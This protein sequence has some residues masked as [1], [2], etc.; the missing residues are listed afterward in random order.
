MGVAEA[1]QALADAVTQCKFEATYPA[2][3]E[4]VLNRI[5]DVLVACV[6]S[7]WGRLLSHDNLLN[8]FQACYR[9]GHYQTEKGRDTSG[10]AA[11]GAG[12]AL[13][14]PAGGGGA[15]RGLPHWDLLCLKREPLLVVEKRGLTRTSLLSR[16]RRA[17]DAGVAA[18]H[19]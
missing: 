18:G 7:P 10:A 6:R 15:Q 5:L 8:I 9:I 2:S 1:V 17:A 13:G 3:D 19:G 4:C 11:G 16:C 12:A 14:W